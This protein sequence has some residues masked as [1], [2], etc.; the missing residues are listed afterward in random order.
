MTI[1][2][3]FKYDKL[4]NE[5]FYNGKKFVQDSHLKN[6]LNRTLGMECIK[7]FI[8]DSVFQAE[9]SEDKKALD[10]GATFFIVLTS[11]K[12]FVYFSSS[13]WAFIRRIEH[14]NSAL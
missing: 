4:T 14:D 12:K 5:I 13:E 6:W 8:H 10:F 1:L 2:L 7:A 3:D 9:I 11:K